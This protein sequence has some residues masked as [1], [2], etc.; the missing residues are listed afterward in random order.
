MSWWIWVLIGLALLAAEFLSTTMHVGF[1]GVGAFIVALA[2]AFG[3]NGE[4][5]L[6]LLVFTITSVLALAVLRPIAVKKLR[7][8]EAPKV[9]SMIGEEA[10]A[11]DDI[12][13]QSRGTAELRGSTWSAQN[14]GQTPVKKGQRCTVD[15]VDGLLLHIRGSG[16]VG[17]SH[18]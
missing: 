18:G 16:T 15:R 1:F 3:W 9:D 17:D 4:L 7:M 2:V 14:V 12:A 10:R 6:Q 8:H 5:W 11:L 13:V